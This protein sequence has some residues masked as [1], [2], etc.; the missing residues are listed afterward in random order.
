MKRMARTRPR[1]CG[2]RS[3]RGGFIPRMGEE[4]MCAVR[5]RW[6]SRAVGGKMPLN[7]FVAAHHLRPYRMRVWSPETSSGH[8]SGE[9]R[10]LFST[11]LYYAYAFDLPTP[12]YLC[13]STGR[14]GVRR[15]LTRTGSAREIEP[16]RISNASATCWTLRPAFEPHALIPREPAMQPQVQRR[17]RS[18]H[19][20]WRDGSAIAGAGAAIAYWWAG[21]MTTTGLIAGRGTTVSAI[22]AGTART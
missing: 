21:C 8:C 11:V 14:A 13:S 16:S 3:T 9:L 19:R 22:R 2:R 18:T 15:R 1:P 17:S 4:P 6:G 7:V 5:R 10:Q 12:R 20:R